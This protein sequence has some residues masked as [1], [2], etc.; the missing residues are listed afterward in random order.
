MVF[1]SP[2]K[3]MHYHLGI[4]NCFILYRSRLCKNLPITFRAACTETGWIADAS[5]CCSD[6]VIWYL[7][8]ELRIDCNEYW[9]YKWPFPLGCE[10]PPTSEQRS[11]TF[12]KWPWPEQLLII[13]LYLSLRFHLLIFVNFA[14]DLFIHSCMY[15]RDTYVVRNNI[16]QLM[17]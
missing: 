12:D 3:S 2:T 5:L 1:W 7:L 9:C 14:N 15:L 6:S 4:I 10:D 11:N 16:L 8:L 13:E 17:E